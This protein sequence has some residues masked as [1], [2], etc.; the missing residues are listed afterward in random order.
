MP[1][2]PVSA[3]ACVQVSASV[4][5]PAC[6]QVSASVSASVSEPVCVPVSDDGVQQV[7]AAEEPGDGDDVSAAEAEQE[8]W[9]KNR[10]SERQL[11]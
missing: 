3:P 5:E 8:P 6:V 2:L 9:R 7:S 10:D 4:S 11:M 1:V